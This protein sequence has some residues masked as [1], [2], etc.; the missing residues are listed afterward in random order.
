MRYSCNDSSFW[1]IQVI[2]VLIMFHLFVLLFLAHSASTVL[3]ITLS[4]EPTR[5][6]TIGN[7]AN[8][9]ITVNLDLADSTTSPL[10]GATSAKC[11]IQP[12]PHGTTHT[13]NNTGT[14]FPA[15]IISSTKFVCHGVPNVFAP[16]PGTRNGADVCHC[17]S[18]FLYWFI[19]WFIS[20]FS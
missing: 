16:G 7:N 10:D 17:L 14:T 12:A 2:Q 3:S 18:I 1:L 6:P 9:N 11:N 8:T 15:E 20:I 4:V 5:I 13:L 19:Y